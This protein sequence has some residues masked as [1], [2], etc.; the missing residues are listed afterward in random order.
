M[1]KTGQ[2]VEGAVRERSEKEVS[3]TNRGEEMFLDMEPYGRSQ[4]YLYKILPLILKKEERVFSRTRSGSSSASAFAPALAQAA[5]A[6]GPL[7]GYLRM[8]TN[9]FVRWGSTSVRWDA[10][11]TMICCFLSALDSLPVSD[12]WEVI[13]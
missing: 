8:E 5:G 12:D 4:R 2:A 9:F 10:I 1:I 7:A 11:S 6:K 3:M 13:L